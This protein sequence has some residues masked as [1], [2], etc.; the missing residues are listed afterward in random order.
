MPQVAGNLNHR[1]RLN[2]MNPAAARAYLG[3][4][5]FDLLNAYN[6]LSIKYQ[7]LLAHVDTANVAG[8]GAANAA[9]F[10]PAHPV[11]LLPAQR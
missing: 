9:T 1:A 10:G 5:L 2:D 3:D 7:A 8:L 6:D 4:C 11:L